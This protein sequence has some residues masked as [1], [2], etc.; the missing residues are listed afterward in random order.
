[1]T[2]AYRCL[3]GWTSFRI[4]CRISA[5]S[6]RAFGPARAR[7]PSPGSGFS[8]R[9]HLRAARPASERELSHALLLSWPGCGDPVPRP[10]EGTRDTARGD[11]FG[12]G[13]K[14]AVC[15]EPGPAH[16]GGTVT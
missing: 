6:D 1:M 13:S 9:W 4:R 14:E 12:R 3:T 15:Q 16:R 11:R 8:S 5:A 7:A 10:A 2:I